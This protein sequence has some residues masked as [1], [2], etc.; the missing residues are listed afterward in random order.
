VAKNKDDNNQQI[1]PDDENPGTDHTQQTQQT[2][3]NSDANSIS[4]KEIESEQ[5]PPSDIP[6]G[7]GFIQLYLPGREKPLVFKDEQT[8]TFGRPDSKRDFVPT[9]D[10]TPDHG[11][12]LGVSRE[13]ARIRRMDGEF[14]V[15]DLNSSNGT[16]VND[17]QLT[18]YQ[19]VRLNSG[20][21]I[22]FAH[23]MVLVYVKTEI[24]TK[25]TAASPANGA[26]MQNIFQVELAVKTRQDVAFQS[27]GM[28]LEFLIK[29]VNQ[30][31]S[32]VHAICRIIRQIQQRD[33]EIISV[34]Q[35]NI[36]KETACLQLML[37]GA[38]DVLGFLS[39][40]MPEFIPDNSQPTDADTGS[41]QAD[42]LADYMLQE[43][44][45]KFLGDK[46]PAYIKELST[47]L[48]VILQSPLELRS[49]N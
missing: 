27:G 42:R 12:L 32:A 18:P 34:Q 39:K 38:L 19:P 47:H 46:R 33:M 13:H 41:I 11:V 15:E 24:P 8:I 9:V 3:I 4:T 5:A 29:E 23:L 35:L 30:Y 6:E 36:Q 40:K 43:L 44:I 10:L 45:Y 25:T 20:D 37:R 2:R 48:D 14:F 21:Q 16:W 26:T 22:R 7:K 17:M 28:R 31:L 1:N 49:S